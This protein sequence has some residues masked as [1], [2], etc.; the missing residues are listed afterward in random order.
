LVAQGTSSPFKEEKNMPINSLPI[1][2]EQKEEKLREVKTAEVVPPH[3]GKN[4][5]GGRGGG[6]RDAPRERSKYRQWVP[7]SGAK[8]DGSF[9]KLLV[10]GADGVLESASVK[11]ESI[12]NNKKE[13]GT[14]EPKERPPK[15]VNNDSLF[16]GVV[17]VEEPRSFPTVMNTHLRRFEVA[18]NKWITIN[19]K[20]VSKWT[21]ADAL[22]QMCRFFPIYTW[23]IAF[24]QWHL[25]PCLGFDYVV[26]NVRVP[27]DLIS[28]LKIWWMDKTPTD[29]VINS[30]AYKESIKYATYYMGHIL[31]VQSNELSEIIRGAC[32]YT[33]PMSYQDAMEEER[34]LALVISEEAK[35][36]NWRRLFFA[37]CGWYI[38]FLV[39]DGYVTK[40]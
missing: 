20:I 8:H 22:Y 36:F 32:K 3:R 18:E 23:Y 14:L 5:G 33:F 30:K 13:D 7:T 34:Y 9:H 38:W 19:Y 11:A 21:I 35:V 31:N 15:P 2:K 6:H 26:K 4:G 40:R 29:F 28:A 10:Q 37:L 27:E 1:N 17:E 12:F 24:G 25:V 16:R 39:Y